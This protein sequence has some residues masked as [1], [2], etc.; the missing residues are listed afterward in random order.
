MDTLFIVRMACVNADLSADQTERVCGGV[1]RMLA[2]SVVRSMRPQHH[3]EAE[4]LV[5]KVLER[6][7]FSKPA[8]LRMTATEACLAVGIE[9]PSR[10]EQS[11]MGRA[12]IKATGR[13]PW[14]TN[15]RHVYVLPPMGAA[16]AA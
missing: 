10:A 15:G 5:A 12:L 6:F 2:D 9:S 13:G 16:S 1:R 3:V 11:A 8:A 4:D 7:D 14:K